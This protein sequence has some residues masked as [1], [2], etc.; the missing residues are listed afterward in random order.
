[1]LKRF[2]AVA[3]TGAVLMSQAGCYH[4]SI[5]TDRAPGGREYSDRQWFTIAGLV[6]LSSPAG[7][8]CPNGLARA[9]SELSGTD[10]LINIGLGVAGA[11]AGAAI[12][13]DESDERV[14]SCAA[15]G[16]TLIPF[17]LGSRTVKYTCVPEARG[18]QDFMPQPSV[19]QG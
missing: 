5:V 12:C 11:F 8:E 1:M 19:P 7:G 2:A 13:K 9:E 3:V 4:T 10:W 18:Q 16:A 14:S 15:T 6:P 17:L